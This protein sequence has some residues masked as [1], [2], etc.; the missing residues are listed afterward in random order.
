[1]YGSAVHLSRRFGRTAVI[2]THRKSGEGE[3]VDGDVWQAADARANL[4]RVMEAALAGKPQVIRRRSGEEVVVVARADY[5]RM[6]PA[7]K[8][9]LLQSAGAAGEDDDA[10]FEE[11]LREVRAT[12][13]LGLSPRWASKAE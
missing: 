1:M 7:L 9:Y 3:M 10:S 13:S 8:D 11:A 12:G 5:D 2:F 4:P 6:K